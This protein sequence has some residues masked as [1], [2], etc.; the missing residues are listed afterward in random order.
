MHNEEE[1]SVV[2]VMFSD[3]KKMLNT[4][5]PQKCDFADDIL[6]CMCVNEE[7]NKIALKIVPWGP[8]DNIPALNQI[9]AWCWSGD[10]PLCKAIIA[11]FT[12]ACMRH[13]ASMS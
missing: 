13:S 3:N 12:D 5:S 7:K 6:K 9:M 4:L 8:I 10:K 11:L 1:A 2:T